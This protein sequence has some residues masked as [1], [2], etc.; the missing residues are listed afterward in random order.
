MTKHTM[1]EIANFFGTAVS[2]DGYRTTLNDE[3]GVVCT[4]ANRL[5]HLDSVGPHTKVKPMENVCTWH[6]DDDGLWHTDCKQMFTL[7]DGTPVENGFKFCPYCGKSLVEEK[8][9]YEDKEDV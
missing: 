3:N 8:F 6:E 9:E 2:F 5:V 7:F 1:Q 4:I